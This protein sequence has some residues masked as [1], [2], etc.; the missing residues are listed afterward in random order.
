MACLAAPGPCRH[1][2]LALINS[3]SSTWPQADIDAATLL[4]VDTLVFL[5]VGDAASRLT[6]SQKSDIRAWVA[7]GGK[8]IIYD[9]DACPVQ[10][11]EWLPYFTADV[12]GALGAR[13]GTLTVEENNTLSSRDPLSSYYIDCASIT[14]N[15][16]AVGD[17][18]VMATR[19]A[20]WC[21]DM[22]AV[23]ANGVEG[24]V[25]AY[26]TY[27]KGLLIY[28]GLDTDDISGSDGL[29]RI[30]RFELEQPFN[31]DWLPHSRPVN[32]V[33]SRQR[34]LVVLISGLGSKTADDEWA[35]WHYVSTRLWNDYHYE[36]FRAK[37][38]PGGVGDVIDSY[39]PDWEESA[40]RLDRQLAAY[41]EERDN[42]V[43][44]SVPGSSRGACRPL[45]GRSD[46]AR[47]RGDLGQ[48]VIRPDEWVSSLVGHS[49][50]D[51]ERW[52]SP[53]SPWS[54]HQFWEESTPPTLWSNWNDLERLHVP[55]E[56]DS[57]EPLSNPHLSARGRVF[58]EWAEER[59]SM[60]C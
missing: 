2:V 12:P 48:G 54:C 45:H 13:G 31:P 21:A 49:A 33:V 29:R 17:A 53:R 42:A 14:A 36:T 56:L 60:G 34:P 55:V 5:Q 44:V 8:F 23:N 51:A 59:S 18:N 47:L 24:I 15:T 3:V 39:S 41:H 40:R 43:V 46:R 32:D 26:A 7:A 37:T 19:D 9:S 50:L 52:F 28:N 27:Q 22:S 20:N 30:W 1:R 10:S 16:D 58:P 25:H 38:R 11:Y 6:S 57:R 4:G 35:D